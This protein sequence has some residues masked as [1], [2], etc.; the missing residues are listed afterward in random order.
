MM[1][2][3]PSFTMSPLRFSDSPRLVHWLNESMIHRTTLS[4]PFPYG[5][6]NAE[7]F[8][9]FANQSESRFGLPT[10]IAIREGDEQL[11]GCIGIDNL[12]VG[13]CGELGYWLAKPY[14][15]RGIMTQCVR[16]FCETAM[17][18]WQLI[19]ISAHVFVG[20]QGSA[21]VLEKSGFHL[22]GT[23]RKYYLKESQSIDAHLY[24][25]LP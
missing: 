21:R 11:I 10:H 3:S 23:L 16:E 20:N 12:K 7:Q 24:A 22:E 2:L 25:L 1:D 13:H 19:R 17:T 9:E 6:D 14:W 15:N 4:I 18:Q 5:D 8:I